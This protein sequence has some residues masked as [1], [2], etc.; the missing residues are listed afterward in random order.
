M[1]TGIIG[2]SLGIVI[3][4]GIQTACYK[5]IAYENYHKAV[6]IALSSAF[7]GILATLLIIGITK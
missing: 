6:V 2:V 4:I 3:I 1:V 5:F 7:L